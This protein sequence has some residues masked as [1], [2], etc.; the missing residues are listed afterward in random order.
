MAI[1]HPWPDSAGEP[2]RCSIAEV[3]AALENAPISKK[4]TQDD[5][6]ETDHEINRIAGAVSARIERYSPGAPSPTKDEALIRA[7]A[8]LED[9]R[10][11]MHPGGIPS[12]D[13]R[14]IPENQSRW[15][16]L[17]GAMGLLSQWRIRNAGVAEE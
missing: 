2:R 11:A 6:D 13:I 4:Q 3:R 1:T 12:L 8:W 9:S 10:G 16:R 17:S 5:L 14:P 15:F 7:V